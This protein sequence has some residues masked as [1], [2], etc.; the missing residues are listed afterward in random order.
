MNEIPGLLYKSP[1]TFSVKERLLLRGG[2]PVIALCVKS[3]MATCRK[4]V[5]H[6]DAIE[7]ACADRGHAILAIWHETLAMAVYVF[8]NTGYHTLTSYS[9]DGEM[10]ARVLRWFGLFAVRG[11][12]SQGGSEAVKNLQEALK[13]VPCVGFTLDGPRGPWRVAKP[14][15][16]VLSARAGVAVVP[17]AV[18][19]S[20]VWR[21]KSWDKMLVPKPGA[22]VVAECGEPIGAPRDDSPEE[23]E[24]MRARVEE[25]LNELHGRLDRSL[26]NG[27][28]T[29]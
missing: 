4:E 9:F 3:L 7:Q 15:I 12:S 23:V 27:G 6:L 5:R 19:A 11:S 2:P 18:V 17:L 16:G 20:P 26:D 25:S 29:G 24:R 1:N 13:H 21:L 28:N 22:R 10:A 8:R 14:G